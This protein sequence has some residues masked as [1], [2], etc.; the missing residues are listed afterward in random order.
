[1]QQRQPHMC[2]PPGRWVHA[3]CADVA[4]NTVCEVTCGMQACV[5]L[6]YVHAC[7]IFTCNLATRCVFGREIGMGD[8][9]CAVMWLWMAKV[10]SPLVVPT[11]PAVLDANQ[12]LE[13]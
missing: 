1:M 4:C 9:P 13:S 10:A 7:I 5:H 8:T 6:S 2:H 3:S 12:G 11:M